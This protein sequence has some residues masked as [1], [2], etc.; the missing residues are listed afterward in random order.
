MGSIRQFTE[1]DIPAVIALRRRAFAFT[2]R[3]QDGA[4]GAYFHE[5]F[6]GRRAEPDGPVSL[7]YE[8][9]GRV[10]GFLGVL[11]RRIRFL[12]EPLRAAVGTQFMV[13]PES[14][15]VPAVALARAFFAGPQ[16]FS[17]S[18]SANDRARRLWCA[19]GGHV[20]L[21]HSLTWTLPLRPA[22]YLLARSNGRAGGVLRRAARPV[23]RAADLLLA[24]H[25]PRAIL[26]PDADLSG[27]AMAQH[28]CRA[29]QERAFAPVYD[30]PTLEWMLRRLP[31][32]KS[33]GE[34]HGSLA[35]GPSGE[36]LGWFLYFLNRRGVSE[37]AQLAAL[38][39]RYGQVLD[40]LLAHAGGRGAVMV[41][42]RLDPALLP[43]LAQRRA[44]LRREGPW[45]LIHSKRPEVLATV[46][47]GDAFLSRLDGEWWLSF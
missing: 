33:L 37:V 24:R 43:E 44:V 46:E 30:R 12:G 27:A 42:G 31:E 34:L 3:P 16:D 11:A 36:A 9:G 2:E 5:V 10:V 6:L 19:N 1:D 14:R 20:S 21:L 35:R 32:K 39:G 45:V 15:G 47:R 28:W 18:D 29:T 22:S 7:V 38:P 40:H 17:L 4:L 8:R 23:A 41:S 13:D 26:E 25:P